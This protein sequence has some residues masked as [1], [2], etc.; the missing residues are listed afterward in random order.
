MSS[1][2][3]SFSRSNAPQSWQSPSRLAQADISLVFAEPVHTPILPGAAAMNLPKHR[4]QTDDDALSIQSGFIPSTHRQPSHNSLHSSVSGNVE[5]SCQSASTDR[6]VL[7]NEVTVQT[8]Q[9]PSQ[10]SLSIEVHNTQVN[11]EQQE[12]QYISAPPQQ[13]SGWFN[14]LRRSNRSTTP[15]HIEEAVPS[16]SSLSVPYHKEFE[17]SIDTAADSHLSHGPGVQYSTETADS[18]V[19]RASPLQP[20]SVPFPNSSSP[21]GDH[22]VSNSPSDEQNNSRAAQSKR[23]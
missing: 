14:S 17:A 12:A 22:S 11:I 1:R 8:A 23:K 5:A 4:R 2:H 20:I 6:H 21:K 7:S 18:V 15:R 9:S 10:L 16:T 19:S 3:S 13:P